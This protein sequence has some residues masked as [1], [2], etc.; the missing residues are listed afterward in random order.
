MRPAT[1]TIKKLWRRMILR[2][3]RRSMESEFCRVVGIPVLFSPTALV[4]W[5]IALLFVVLCGFA[6]WME[7]GMQ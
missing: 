4:L 3:Y 7:G 5:A 1:T 2:L 6:G